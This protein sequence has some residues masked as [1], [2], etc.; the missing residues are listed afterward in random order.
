[1]FIYRNLYIRIV[2]ARLA[3]WFVH[4][5]TTPEAPCSI[6]G[7]ETKIFQ[8]ILH[9]FACF[10]VL[11][12]LFVQSGTILSEIVEPLCPRRITFHH[13]MT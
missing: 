13:S 11:R 4:W 7:K 2:I 9:F 5:S 12:E 6:H 8:Y 10:D 1:M 3:Q